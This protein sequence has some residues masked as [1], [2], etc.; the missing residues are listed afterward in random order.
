MNSESV[1]VARDWSQLCFCPLGIRQY[2][3]MASGPEKAF[4]V[5]SFL[6]TKS[7]ARMKRQFRRNYGKIPPSNRQFVLGTRTREACAK[8]RHE[9]SRHMWQKVEYLFDVPRVIRGA[10]IELY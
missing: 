8:I 2:G 7:I 3:K 5:F 10:H 6:E 4:Y 1:N 9:I